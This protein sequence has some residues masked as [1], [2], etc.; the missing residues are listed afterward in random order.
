MSQPLDC[1]VFGSFKSG[2]RKHLRKALQLALSSPQVLAAFEDGDDEDQIDENMTNG[3]EDA[4]SE[5]GL[6]DEVEIAVPARSQGK[7]L[8]QAQRRDLLVE[9]AKMALYVALYRDTVRKSFEVTGICPPSLDTALQ[10]KGITNLPEMSQLDVN[11][12]Q[13]KKRSRRSIS[14]IHLNHTDSIQ[15]LKDEDKEAKNKSK[16]ARKRRKEN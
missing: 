12:T 8:T 15:M 2:L 14:G 11:L 1:L 16:P 7:D 10:R 6:T 5:V 13:S 9:C 3:A 4:D